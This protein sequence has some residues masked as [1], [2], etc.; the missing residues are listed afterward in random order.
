MIKEVSFN[1]T[2]GYSKGDI[3]AYIDDIIAHLG[4]LQCYS[5]SCALD[6]G[7]AMRRIVCVVVHNLRVNHNH[8]RLDAFLQVGHTRG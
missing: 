5:L 1:V 8:I 6:N 2:E 3:I 7:R 4:T